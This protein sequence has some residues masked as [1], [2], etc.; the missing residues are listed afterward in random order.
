MV[1]FVKGVD[2]KKIAG[3][4]DVADKTTLGNFKPV[5]TDQ[6]GGIIFGNSLAAKL[7]AEKCWILSATV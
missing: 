5:M 4:S 3:L 7:D 6:F 1:A 2:D